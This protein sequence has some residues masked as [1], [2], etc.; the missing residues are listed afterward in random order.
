MLVEAV[1]FAIVS[2]SLIA[3]ITIASV[4]TNSAIAGDGSIRV[5]ATSKDPRDISG[6]WWIEQYNAD[7]KPPLNDAGRQHYEE[8]VQ[9][10]AD[11]SAVDPVRKYCLPQ[12]VVGSMASPYPFEILQTPGIMAILLE[13]HH[14]PRL[15]YMDAPHPP[16]ADYAQSYRGHSVGRWE[17]DT[18]VIDTVYFNGFV[19]L[20]AVGHP[21]SDKLHVVERIRKRDGGKRLENV[22]TVEDSDYYRE[23]FTIRLT[24][25][26]RP[27]VDIQEWACGEPHRDIAGVPGVTHSRGTQVSAA[28]EVSLTLLSPEKVTSNR[29]SVVL[30]TFR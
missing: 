20:D 14:T 25:A 19:T 17:G 16:E 8:L 28:P 13:S 6:V 7:L 26:W 29:S 24:Y 5:Q 22:I 21:T 15:I 4:G 3:A 12:G 27:D 9:G 30:G 23:P 1:R 10:I 18:L 2:V 11:G